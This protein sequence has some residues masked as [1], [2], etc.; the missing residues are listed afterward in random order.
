MGKIETQIRVDCYS[1]YRSEE[2]PR[3]FYLGEKKLEIVEVMSR[4]MEPDYRWFKV[5]GDDGGLYALRQD[6]RLGNWVLI[7]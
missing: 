1:G 2:T 5:R 6:I 7:Q 3:S 4:W